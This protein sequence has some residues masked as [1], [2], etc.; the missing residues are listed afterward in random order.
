MFSLDSQPLE[1]HRS[2][3]VQTHAQYLLLALSRAAQ[4]IQRAHTLEDF[5]HA[6]GREIQLLGGNVALL[7]LNEDKQ[8]LSIAYISYAPE[9]IRKAEQMTGLSLRT[10]QLPIL[11]DGV[12]ERT[13]QGRKAIFIDSSID[14]LK[15]V[16]PKPIQA[17][18]SPLTTVFNLRQG[19]LV[20]LLVDDEVLGLLKVIGPFLRQDD[21]SAMEAFAGQVAAGLRNVWLVQRLQDELTA[22]RKT[23]LSLNHNRDLLLALSRA[24]HA[25]QL[26]REP[27]DI[28]QVV[29]E[30]IRA[31][32]FEATILKFGSDKKSLH[33]RYTT[34][35]EK[36]IHA[37]EQ[38]AGM[39][40]EGFGWAISQDSIYA[41]ILANRRA[42]YISNGKY[43]FIEVLPDFLRPLAEK[44]SDL[45]SSQEGILAPLH[46]DDETFGLLLVFGNSLLSEED[47]PAVESF[48]AQVSVSLQNAHLTHRLQKELHERKQA[49]IAAKEAEKTLL[50]SQSTFEGIFNKVTETIYIQDENGVFLDVNEGA[51]KMYGYPREHF[52][53]RTPEFLSA[54]G[55]ND[56]SRIA[57]YVQ[58]AFNGQH[59]EF[60]FW[61]EKKDGSVFPKDVRLNAGMYFD[62]KVVIAVARDITERKRAE[63]ALRSSEAKVHALLDAVPDILF[64]MTR[65][66]EYVDYYTSHHD[67][68]LVS[69][70]DFLGKNIRDVMPQEISDTYFATQERLLLSGESQL[71]EYSLALPDGI[72]EFE[73]HVDLY[74]DEYILCV[75]RDV[76]ERKRAE[77]AVRQA[78]RRSKA[79]IENAPD[80]VSLIGMDG[81]IKY[82][83]PSAVKMFGYNNDD[84]VEE[85]PVDSIHPEDVGSVIGVLAELVNDPAFVPNIA[86]LHPVNLYGGVRVTPVNEISSSPILSE[87]LFLMKNPVVVVISAVDSFTVIIL[88]FSLRGPASVNDRKNPRSLLGTG[89]T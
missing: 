86:L 50:I 62:K 26:V 47:L 57:E 44:L 68:L 36:V 38:L 60:E 79:M 2:R 52:I 42:E 5:Y 30:Q 84:Y 49:E 78:E 56:L 72:H 32:G 66:G 7:M 27:E 87:R 63:E 76:T 61:G 55:R 70:A 54:P 8:S 58:Q 21:L 64:V 82:A 35:S 4:A 73:T 41:R 81:K 48:S 28:Y 17:L 19:V 3:E 24:S 74:H 25:I 31:L 20:P 29:G 51:E 89:V 14:T 80:G 71:F 69:P 88:S 43:L 1:G 15:E 67:E 10:Y 13:I 77:K 59:V 18:S 46:V 33:F 23:E 22:H 37:A 39:K 83:S 9:L 45:L 6:V 75:A 34:I 85:N 40:A 12:Y 65:D 16:L 53:G 11:S